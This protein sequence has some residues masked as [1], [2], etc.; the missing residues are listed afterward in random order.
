MDADS[1]DLGRLRELCDEFGA[2]LLVDEAHALGVLGPD[3]RGLLAAAGVQ[4]E[5]LVGTLGKA[6]GAGGAFVLGCPA[7]IEWLW[8]R[9]RSFVFS[10]GLSPALAR[11]GLD[12]LQQV[13][14]D[15]APRARVLDRAAQLREGLV[16]MGRRPLGYG[17]VVPW[18]VGDSARAVHYA[19]LLQAKGFE[20]QA[21]RPPSVPA[22]TARLR[23]TASARQSPEDVDS[24]LAAIAELSL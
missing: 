23:F 6:F 16:K 18:V 14:R 5:A 24:L 9:A 12:A 7:L 11:A 15:S 4:A 19:E 17:H 10:T 22:N 8:N 20:V 1:P 21:I 13:G 3:G 2:A